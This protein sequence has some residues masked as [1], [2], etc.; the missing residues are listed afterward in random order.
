MT[1]SDAETHTGCA[2]RVV[3]VVRVKANEQC[4]IR[5]LSDGRLE[6]VIVKRS[7]N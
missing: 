2:E 3:K 6:I 1:G 7:V 4:T 5:T